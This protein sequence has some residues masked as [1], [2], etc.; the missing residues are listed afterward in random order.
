VVIGNQITPLDVTLDGKKHTTTTDLELIAQH[1]TP[2][3]TITLQL[4]ATTVAY[5]EPRL[6]GRITFDSINIS[7]PTTNLTPAG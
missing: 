1:L 4:V 7:L 6:D 5:A 2:G 3:H